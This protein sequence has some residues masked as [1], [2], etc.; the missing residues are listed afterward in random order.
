MAD[1]L[2][3]YAHW[4]PWTL[5]IKGLEGLIAGLI[6]H[7]AY[8]AGGP[9]KPQALLGMLVSV[10]WMVF[11]YYIAGGLMKG[12]PAS[13]LSVPGNMIQGYGSVILALPLLVVLRTIIKR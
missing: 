5:V 4:A 7:R 11:G 13:L 1:L 8:R 6:A 2:S 3:G 10:S 9:F 12:F